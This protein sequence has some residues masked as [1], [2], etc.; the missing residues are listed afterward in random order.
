MKKYLIAILLAGCSVNPDLEKVS[1]KMA[2]NVT[3]NLV[4]VQDPKTGYCYAL[5]QSTTGEVVRV[6]VDMINFTWVPCDA[7]EK[8]HLTK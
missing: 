4:Y 2:K 5:L 1:S 3:D 6:T 8:M 7:L